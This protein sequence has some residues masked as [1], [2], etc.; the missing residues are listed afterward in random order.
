MENEVPS[1]GRTP[2]QSDL[3]ALCRALNEHGARYLVVGGIAINHHG[4]IRATEDIDIL[5]D[6]DLENQRRVKRAL[7][8]LPDKAIAGST[9]RR[10][11]I[12]SRQRKL[13]A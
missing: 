7:E 6:L 2:N 11:A 1:P 5:V 9:L 13:K 8:I 3:V 4:F 12:R 10:R